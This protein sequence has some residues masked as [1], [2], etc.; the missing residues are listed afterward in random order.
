MASVIEK[1]PEAQRKKVVDA[2]LAGQSLRKVAK[3]AGV[4][5]TQV[6]DYKRTKFMPMLQAA[7]KLNAVRELAESPEDQITNTSNLTRAALAADPLL[8]RISRHQA[9]LDAEI[10]SATGDARG[11]AALIGTDLRG[12]ELHAKLTGRLDAPAHQTNIMIVCPAGDA[13]AVTLEPDAVT[14]DIGPRK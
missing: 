4:S 5:H 6:D 8:S 14:I 9:T 2:L 10:A 12:I 3:I 11:V 1:L 13:P 7:Q